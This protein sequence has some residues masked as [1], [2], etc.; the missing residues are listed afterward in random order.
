M[1]IPRF[2]KTF[3]SLLRANNL[4]L[5]GIPRNVFSLSLDMNGI[6]HQ[7]AQLCYAYSHDASDQRK[8]Y[9]TKTSQEIL[10]KEYQRTV[11]SKIM[12][13]VQAIRPTGALIMAVDGVCPLA[14]IKQQRQRR[15]KAAA[16]RTSTNPNAFD[17]NAISTG[18]DFMA[19]L[20]AYLT[21]WV[22]KEHLN[23]PPLVIFSGH[24]VPNEGEHKVMD[25]FR[26]REELRGPHKIHVVH[27]LDADLI[28]L[29]ALTIPNALLYREDP[30]QGD[31]ILNIE[32]FKQGIKSL[33]GQSNTSMMDFTVMMSFVGNDFLP[34]VIS[35]S[36]MA[37]SLHALARVY[38]ETRIPLTDKKGQLHWKNLATFLSVVAD[39]EPEMFVKLSYQAKHPLFIVENNMTSK[40]TIDFEQLKIDW[41][42][43]IL[44]PPETAA[45]SFILSEKKFAPLFEMNDENF[46]NM[47]TQYMTG[48][49]WCLKYYTEGPNKTN[50]SWYYPYFHA[51]LF[52]ELA[53]ITDQMDQSFL[54]DL[55]DNYRFSIPHQLLSVLPVQSAN[56]IPK[57]I[58]HFATDEWSVIRDLFPN[59]FV[60][61]TEASKHG[62][63]LVP[64][65]DPQRIIDAVDSVV[66]NDAQRKYYFEV[67][68]DLVLKRVHLPQP[69]SMKTQ[70]KFSI[71]TAKQNDRSE[72]RDPEGS[73]TRVW[74]AVYKN[75]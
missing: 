40:D 49:S 11:S 28:L 37:D 1:G 10:E 19:R 54:D 60:M 31:V 42:N 23:L 4:T 52:Y 18:T 6:L 35:T 15:Y 21:A 38:R 7:A 39:I 25:I 73:P 74:N 63:A 22:K 50:M 51:P 71:R 8:A 34:G 16:E 43:K 24:L 9:V 3:V 14:K 47:L 67:G 2:Y 72:R 26:T 44:S 53:Q 41:Y 17:S 62:N 20:D 27:G 46:N 59:T 12:E 30:A 68:K 33:L 65:V 29:S 64:F 32:A 55:K 57:S 48:V 45:S 66:W 13:L 69:Q 61:D 75:K 56:L 36:N 70:P 58:R 5:Q